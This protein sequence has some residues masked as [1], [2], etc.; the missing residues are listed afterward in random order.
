MSALPPSSLPSSLES[1]AAESAGNAQSDSALKSR[2]RGAKELT[3]EFA[4]DESEPK[5]EVE[6]TAG[7]TG[8]IETQES[9]ESDSSE[10]Q[11]GLEEDTGFDAK[12]FLKTVPNRPGCYRMYN[13]RDVVI[14]V[15]KAKDLKRRLSSYFLNKTSPTP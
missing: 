1:A 7:E 13:D 15:G 4:D 10:A 2:L 11:D 12:A 3:I 8:V 6:V 9:S 5:P 14:Y